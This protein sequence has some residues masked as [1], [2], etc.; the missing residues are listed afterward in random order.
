MV[1]PEDR[2]APSPEAVKASPDGS[3]TVVSGLN[4]ISLS[5]FVL[6]AAYTVYVVAEDAA[7]NLSTAPLSI[8]V[9][10]RQIG[11]DPA[12]DRA[13]QNEAAL[14]A[15]GEITLTA[16]GGSAP[17]SI[18]VGEGGG[19]I[20]TIDG[21]SREYPYTITENTITLVGGGSGGEDAKISY[22]IGEGTLT[23]EGLDKIAGGGLSGGSVTSDSNPLLTPPVAD[24]P[25]TGDM[26]A[27]GTAISG[28]RSA[29]E[30]AVIGPADSLPQGTHYVTIEDK[31]AYLAAIEEA[32]EVYDAANPSAI[33]TALGSLTEAT[34][35]FTAA[36]MGHTVN[37]DTGAL[38]T[39]IGTLQTWLDG[40]AAVFDTAAQAPL[41]VHYLTAAQKTAL[42]G[43]IDGAAGMKDDPGRTGAAV[44]VAA[45]SVATAQTTDKGYY[46]SQIGTN[47]VPVPILGVTA[48]SFDGISYG[49]ARPE[50][51]S[52]TITNSGTAAANVSSLTLSGTG[53]KAFTLGGSGSTVSAG[54]SIA[55]RTVQPA[56][57]LGAGTHTATITVSYDNGRTAAAQVSITI[58]KAIPAYTV[59]DRLSAFV[60]QTLAD[61]ALPKGFSWDTDQNPLTTSVGG[62][63]VNAFKAQFTPG[64]LTNYVVVENIPVNITV[65]ITVALK[66]LVTV[67][68]NLDHEV[69]VTG[70]PGGG[71]SLSRAGETKTATIS[72]AE[73]TGV[74]WYVDGEA[75][76]DT[77]LG[78]GGNSI[79]LNAAG[80]DVR[81]HS[82]TFRGVQRGITYSKDIDFTVTR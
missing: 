74:K 77:R 57:A 20:V 82:V 5:N 51:K 52:I 9:R 53:A 58:T 4:A 18:A 33:Q 70:V 8:P 15:A 2:Q 76:N 81:N 43:I 63:G 17:A 16:G 62:A 72:A 79:T 3:G 45:S 40:V 30:D 56:A 47:P 38:T 71:I 14:I 12:K 41:G 78:V 6:G 10:P 25:V 24:T 34:E 65:N 64:D 23:L 11:A 48:I 29:Y 21:T 54:G 68:L 66:T 7:G 13:D 46:D 73:Y 19:I 44:A 69:T 37:V 39:A 61:V 35:T 67:S 55:T 28:A 1:L 31:D 36:R 42:Q 75:V 27:L 80:Y 26:A 59:P 50:A 49:D 60:G 22:G 32:Q